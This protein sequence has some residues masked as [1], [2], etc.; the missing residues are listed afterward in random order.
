MPGFIRPRILVLFSGGARITPNRGPSASSNGHQRLTLVIKLDGKGIL[1]FFKQR[2]GP[3]VFNDSAV[4]AVYH[5]LLS[6]DFTC[7]ILLGW[8]FKF[9]TGLTIAT[10]CQNRK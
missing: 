5:L 3:N 10:C 4:L 2:M 7:L 1:F 6:V 8:C 9:F